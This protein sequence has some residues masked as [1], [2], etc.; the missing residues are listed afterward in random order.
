MP[1]LKEAVHIRRLMLKD[2]D[3][4]NARALVRTLSARPRYLKSSTMRVS[5]LWLKMSWQHWRVE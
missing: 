5:L 3:E 2:S 1:Y 4:P